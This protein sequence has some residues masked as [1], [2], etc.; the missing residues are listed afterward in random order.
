MLGLNPE[1]WTAHARQV[2]SE[3]NLKWNCGGILDLPYQHS[4]TYPVGVSTWTIEAAPL[5]DDLLSLRLELFLRHLLSGSRMEGIISP[6]FF[7]SIQT[8]PSR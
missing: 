5:V 7:E 6:T 4:R 2:G 3:G 8:G 1:A